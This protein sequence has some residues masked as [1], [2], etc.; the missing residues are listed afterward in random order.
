MADLPDAEDLNY[1]KTSKSKPATW[2]EKAERIV[3][4][5]LEGVVLL[6]AKGRYEGG[7]AW[8]MEFEVQGDRFRVVWPI[9]PSRA[10]NE[11]AAERQAATMLYHD[12]KQRSIRARVL[13]ARAAY[14]EYFL[15]GDGRT[16]AD[17][18]RKELQEY[19]PNRLLQSGAASH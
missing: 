15:L 9:L 18:G 6:Y 19:T 7:Y 13:G 1:F 8:A 17:L 16:A 2:L 3:E 14:F 5:D 12:I 11:T 10:N 4:R